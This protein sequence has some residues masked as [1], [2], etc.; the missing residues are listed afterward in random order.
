MIWHYTVGPS[1]ESI[2]DD[3]F[4]R[5]ATAGVPIGERPIVWFSMDQYWENTVIKGNRLPDG[6]VEVLK[7][8]GLLERG[9]SLFRI[10]V[11][12]AVA[13]YK[14]SELKS[15]SGMSSEMARGLKASAKKHNANPS[16]WRGTFDPVTWEKWE[17][18]ECFK[19]GDWVTLE[20][21]LALIHGKQSKTTVTTWPND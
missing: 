9:F 11:D 4:I 2:L 10:G 3:G 6:T 7:M 18:F 1:F 14:W 12:A 8:V 16:S 21:P 20:A 15:L 5:P 19:S 13:P 17:A